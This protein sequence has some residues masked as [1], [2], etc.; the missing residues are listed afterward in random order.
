MPKYIH[1]YII[2]FLLLIYT[3]IT[4]SNIKN[5]FVSIIY[6]PLLLVPD[7]IPFIHS[8]IL[9]LLSSQFPSDS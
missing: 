2:Q 6:F 7:L 9:I 1:K 3:K 4:L 5:Q 8:R